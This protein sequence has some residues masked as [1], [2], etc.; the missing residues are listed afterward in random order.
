M[1]CPVC[2][3]ISK[4]RRKCINCGWE[5]INFT[6]EPS[7]QQEKEYNELLSAY[8]IQHG[9]SHE[10]SEML[11]LT[12]D[13]F[14]KDMFETTQEHIDRVNSMGIFEVGIAR[15]KEYDADVEIYTIECKF[16]TEVGD[17]INDFSLVDIKIKLPRDTAKELYLEGENHK[18]YAHVTYDGSSFIMKEIGFNKYPI[19][20]LIEAKKA[21]EAVKAER[22]KLGIY[23]DE[24]S[25]LIWQDTIDCYSRLSWDDA[26]EYANNLRLGGYDD[27]FLPSKE[28][29][30][31]LHNNQ[32]KLKYNV[33][34][35]YWSSSPHV[36]YSDIAWYV[37]FKRDASN[38][39]TKLGN[40]YVRCARAGQ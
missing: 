34:S 22:I 10:T 30:L 35:D 9:F 6:E 1:L 21:T 3:N 2:E 15:L 20:K 38:I 29:L 16:Q 11:R 13:I 26:M 17:L 33:S 37:N 24:A 23:Y 4:K 31:S 32:D 5:F 28:Q 19:S 18:I 14:K 12:A 39:H 7:K 27:W 8:K 25:G 36:S 40:C